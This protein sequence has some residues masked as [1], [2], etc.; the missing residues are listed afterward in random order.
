MKVISQD[1]RERVEIFI[2]LM[3]VEKKA[4][5]R[6]VDYTML[7]RWL[8]GK[9]V[10]ATA[11][12]FDHLIPGSSRQEE[13]HARLKEDK[14]RVIATDGRCCNTDKQMGEDVRLAIS[15]MECAAKSGCDTLIVV[16]GDGDFLPLM[17]PVRSF[18]KKIEFA[19]F[20]ECANQSLVEASDSFTSLDDLPFIIREASA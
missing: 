5:Q 14:F 9:R 3:N 20:S 15:V 2:D 4:G 12:V 6:K 7:C 17:E 10:I 1:P 16:S 18:G 13:N 19:A 8:A 11:S